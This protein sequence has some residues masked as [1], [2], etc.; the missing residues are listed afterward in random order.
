MRG[1]G[2]RDVLEQV[3]GELLAQA[4]A[5]WAAAGGPGGGVGQDAE[6]AT[7]AAVERLVDAALLVRRD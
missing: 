1:G 6:A 3:R 5:G 2:G 4:G 7:A